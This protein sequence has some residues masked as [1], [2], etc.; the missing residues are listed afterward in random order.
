MNEK[1]TLTIYSIRCTCFWLISTMLLI[2]ADQVTKKLAVVKLKNHSGFSIIPGVLELSYLENKGMAFGMF[3]GKQIL[4]II[5]S[6]AFCILLFYLL[7]R[8]PK[9]PYYRPLMV[10]GSVLAA[11]ALGNFIDRLSHGYVIDFIY[12]SLINF[13]IFNLADIFVVCGGIALVLFVLFRYKDEDFAFILPKH[14]H[15]K[16]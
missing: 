5:L 16:G 1:Q 13:P 6:I 3:Q 11:G 14:T 10:I 9:T 7:I 12:F 8:I 15:K 2:I 4:F